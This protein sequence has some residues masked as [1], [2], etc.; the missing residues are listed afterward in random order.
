[1]AV[2]RSSRRRLR[3]S[4][5]SCPT[6]TT[7]TG[8]APLWQ[9]SN[10]VQSPRDGYYY[11]LVQ[12]DAH[13]ADGSVNVQGMCLMPTN[14]LA[15][16]GSWRAWDGSGFGVQFMDPYTAAAPGVDC[17]LVSPSVGALTYGL[18]YN[19]YA[20]EFIAVGVRA[21]GF[22]YSTSADLINWSVARPLM[23]ATQVFTPGGQPPFL[24]YPT[25]IDPASPSASFDVTG[26]APYLYF[27]KMYGRSA[28]D[29]MDVLRIE[30]TVSR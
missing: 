5:P 27:T 20:G 18:S 30:V 21:A 2:P 6:G 22:F 16:P 29:G 24:T 3:T 10:I 23:A 4:S 9:P 14:N 12:Y 25:L 28:D 13:A 19:S 15:A 26:Q 17:T 7:L 1:M 8:T 11:A